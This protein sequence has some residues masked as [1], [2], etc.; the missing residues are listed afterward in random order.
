MHRY[1]K[2]VITALLS[3]I[4]LFGYASFPSEGGEVYAAAKKV[5]ADKVTL[6]HANYTLKKGKVIQLKA[7]VF[8]VKAAKNAKL[9]WKS[10]N[11]KVALVSAKGKVKALKNGK[12]KI[13]VSVKGTKKK[14]SCMIY[15]GTPLKQVKLNKTSLTLEVGES[16][17]LKP[18]YTPKKS[19]LKG[20]KYTSSNEKVATV[21]AKGVIKAVEAGKTVITVKPKDEA[22][23][24]V[25]C[26]VTVKAKT[27]EKPEPAKEDETKKVVSTLDWTGDNADLKSLLDSETKKLEI[28]ADPK[29]AVDKVLWESSD[30]ALTVSQDGTLTPK[31]GTNGTFIITV[32]VTD[33]AGNVKKLTKEIK[34]TCTEATVGTEEAVKK[35]LQNENLCKLT[36]STN[37]NVNINIPEGEY[38]DVD[39]VIDMPKGHV[40]NHANFKSVTVK[41]ISGSTYVEYALGNTI[42]FI[43]D[44]GRIQIATGANAV[45]IIEQGAGNLD[46]VNDGNISA[47]NI[48]TKVTINISGE[49]NNDIK[50]TVDEAAAAS[51]IVTSIELDM[52]VKSKVELEVRGGAERTTVVAVNPDTAPDVSG[53]GVVRVTY[54]D[55]T[56]T[57][58][59][60]VAKNDGSAAEDNSV[61]INGKV[62]DTNGQPLPGVEIALILYNGEMSVAE[63]ENNANTDRKVTSSNTG[64]YSIEN[65]PAGNYYLLARCVG[66]VSSLTKVNIEGNTS[67]EHTV[68]D[69]RMIQKTDE[70]KTGSLSGK[71]I[72]AVS[73]NPAVSELTVL[74]RT[75]SNNVTG[76]AFKETSTDN[77]GN[78]TFEK[79][80]YGQYTVQVLD[81]RGDEELLYATA[82]FGVTVSQENVIAPETGL[83]PVVSS[84]QV[85]FVL[86]WGNE[87]SGASSDLDSHLV[88]PSAN[89]KFRFHTWYSD[90]KYYEGD[91]LQADLDLDDTEWEGPE[92]TTIRIKAP[93]VYSF[94]VHDYTNRGNNKST[95]MAASSAV[96][97]VYSGTKTI[98]TFTMPNKAG[99][100][101]YVCDF[102]A[103]SNKIIPRNEI[104]LM[105]GKEDDIGLSDEDILNRAITRL[106]DLVEEA[107]GIWNC[108]SD[109]AYKTEGKGLIDTAKATLNNR[110]LAT[111]TDSYDALSD[112]VNKT[113]NALSIDNVYTGS[114]EEDN[115][116]TDYDT[117]SVWDDD[118]TS[119]LY[120]VL[121]LKG[122]QAQLPD[123]LHIVFRN[124]EAEYTIDGSDRTGF[125][126]MVR[127][128]FG[129]KVETYYI[130]YGVDEEYLLGIGEVRATV[131]AQSEDEGD[132]NQV[133]SWWT[134]SKWIGEGEDE[135]QIHTLEVEG[136]TADIPEQLEVTAAREGA[137]AELKA[138][139]RD[140]Y[141]KMAVV[142]NGNLS[143]NYYVNYRADEGYLLGI[144]EVRATVAAQSEDE[145]DINQV[146]SWWTSSK[147][148]GEG[149]DETQIHTLE[150][151]GMTA[152]IPEQL[153]VTAAREGATAELKASDRDGYDKMA[154]V[155]N[156]NLSRNYYVKYCADPN[157]MADY[158]DQDNSPEDL[159]NPS[160]DPED[161]A[162]P[163]EDPE[164]PANP[165]EDPED[166]RDLLEEAE[167]LG[168][169]ESIDC[170][171]IEVPSGGIAFKFYPKTTATY[172]LSSSGVE[173]C[174]GELYDSNRNLI[175]QNNGEN[176]EIIQELNINEEYFI[177]MRAS[178]SEAPLTADL[179][180]A[181][182]ETPDDS[183]E[184]PAEVLSEDPKEPADEG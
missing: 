56:K 28:K 79:L 5:M 116:I 182:Y 55:G 108:L 34:V 30:K 29:E 184:D 143:R 89:G 53:L 162:N 106:E 63:A 146:T 73:G 141:D 1:Y 11:K 107:E 111:I 64:V 14:A 6:N 21:T 100:L 127:A 23:K 46:L 126:K 26:T 38:P 25:K 134:S 130:S 78:Y 115:I 104:K 170:E 103:R 36:I 152:D 153:E 165:S 42:I 135:T 75:G 124:E 151:E 159:A 82:S 10:G 148:I 119:V 86:S 117:N 66:Y 110:D 97:N 112:W 93:G 180:I 45:V 123:D 13:T 52:I 41:S 113:R 122:T 169:I 74:I 133:T 67:Q 71:L 44:N 59:Y 40:E 136:M 132:I 37:E 183:L 172:R 43:A 142:T 128:S 20:V 12:T 149:E 176:F 121:Y 125:D 131:A 161:L 8:P 16:F 15:V 154:V 179:H 92:T 18:A 94:Y 51:K 91:I 160:E 69:I 72:D 70:V 77:A 76:T 65:V 49:S 168:T 99:V 175:N 83:S 118:D 109:G 101:W 120:K 27:I 164:D 62:L 140:G 145:G 144:G 3:L 39:L 35:A 157:Y 4:M 105:S 102:D 7:K 137:T 48:E 90:K 19:T 98:G 173:D 81:K 147:W 9:V 2:V 95:Q 24:A 150:V 22:A 47:L 87:A 58:D 156:G 129:G 166:Q 57:E 178:D 114:G 181:L 88:G 50:T 174:V 171:G 61:I 163:S 54:S 177:L 96:V 138:S 60:I 85:R 68:S 17:T 32:S 31:S 33:K 155:T 167:D 84:D 139:D 80:P 158:E